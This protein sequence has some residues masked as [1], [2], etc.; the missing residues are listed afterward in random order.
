MT[1]QRALFTGSGLPP[2]LKGPFN[3]FWKAYPPRSPNPRAMAEAEFAAAVKAGR[4]PADLV[5]AAQGYAAECKRLA[6]NPAYIVHAATFLRQGRFLDYVPAPA[7][8]ATAAA[9]AVEIDHPLWP[10]L[11]DRMPAAEFRAWI[12][13]CGVVSWTEGET[14]LLRAP[15]TFVRNWIRANFLVQLRSIAKVVDIDI[16][17]EVEP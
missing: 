6:I 11:R 17:G 15:S 2:T 12:G 5:A 7:G 1:R 16:A 9:P 10:A 14:L 8:D 13:K 3:D 4:A